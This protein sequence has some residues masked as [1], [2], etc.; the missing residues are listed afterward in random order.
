[1]V[2]LSV[3]NYV[4]NKGPSEFW[5]KRKIFKLSAHFLGRRRNCYSIA[6]R[7]V[8]RAL[9]YATQGRRLMKQ[10]MKEL[11]DTRIEAAIAP[12][13]LT[14][15]PFMEALTRCNILLNRKSL[16]DLAIWE[17]RSFESIAKIA[18]ARIK[19]DGLRGASNLEY[20]SGVITRG[21]IKWSKKYIL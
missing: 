18:Q 5:R 11:R 21:M 9:V 16:S 17:P 20:P 3:V 7:N 19:Q 1:M 2:F 8:H 15:L 4:R 10:N 6:I 14:K 13:G 12:Y